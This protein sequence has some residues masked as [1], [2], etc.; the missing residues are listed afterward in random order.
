MPWWTAK[1]EIRTYLHQVNTPTKVLEYSLFQPGLFL[2]Y[3]ATPHKTAEFLT[4]LNTFIDMAN[5]RAIVVQGY[6]DDA[7]M[8]FTTVQ[9]LAALVAAAVEY[10][11][12]G[13]PEV[14][15]IRGNALPISKIIEIG[16]RVRGGEKFVVEKVKMEDLEAGRL[17]ASWGLEA[18]HGSVSGEEAQRLL[19]QVLVG[20]LIGSAKGAWEVSDEWNRL[21]PGF[22]FTGVEEFLEKAWA[23]K[24]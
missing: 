22:A 16:E 23:G 17:T 1:D 20:T 14:G 9:D 24:D 8:T 21:L 5:R 19:K 4:P 15:G 12:G 2:N 10:E 13:W 3:L 6:E 7:V 11:D 18:K